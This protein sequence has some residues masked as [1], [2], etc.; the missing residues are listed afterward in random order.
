[1][2][3]ESSKPVPP[4]GD[5]HEMSL[6]AILDGEAGDLRSQAEKHVRE[7]P[8]CESRL[9]RMRALQEQMDRFGAEEREV[10]VA[11]SD[12][13]DG[14]H[15]APEKQEPG[16]ASAPQLVL[17]RAALIA[18]TL[19]IGALL[20]RFFEDGETS[21]PTDHS[22]TRDPSG[23]RDPALL[24]PGARLEL[25]HPSGEVEQFAPFEWR[26]EDQLPPAGSF[27]LEVFDATRVDEPL[28]LEK[29]LEEPRWSPDPT[30]LDGI[31]WP[32]QIRWSVEVL[33]PQ[34]AI[35]SADAEAT[36]R[37]I[38]RDSAETESA[39]AS[40]S[41]TTDEKAQAE[42][43]A[44]IVWFYEVEEAIAQ[45]DTPGADD[46]G[47][48]RLSKAR[49]TLL[50]RLSESAFDLYDAIALTRAVGHLAVV[51]ARDS[52]RPAETSPSA[53]ALLE[54]GRRVLEWLGAERPRPSSR[55][56]A[57]A[58]TSCPVWSTSRPPSWIGSRAP[59][60]T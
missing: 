13:T 10:L 28:V 31:V 24:G 22:A 11:S 19:L 46:E 21:V 49:A 15:N 5:I 44:K 12:M 37:V 54:E 32:Q 53:E 6:F 59:R 34:G 2:A 45:L 29:R 56:S 8:S 58:R 27:R 43:P 40:S 47:R 55:S 4:S 7:C 51:V 39:A 50:P 30:E 33:G 20:W 17:R 38:E 41:G 48:A 25:L 60:S 26:F 16:S 35:D 18:A 9:E 3:S 14:R 57:E 1:M 36:Q 23:T 42:E 52:A